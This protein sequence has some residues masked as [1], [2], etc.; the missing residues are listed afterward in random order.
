MPP[1]FIFGSGTSPAPNVS[2]LT[3]LVLGAHMRRHS[4]GIFRMSDS[5]GYHTQEA[6]D[7]PDCIRYYLRLIREDI[8]T[9]QKRSIDEVTYEDVANIVVQLDKETGS[10]RNAAL[11]PYRKHLVKRMVSKFPALD[12]KNGDFESLCWAATEW[13][14]W[15]IY[16]TLRDCKKPP[17]ALQAFIETFLD[18]EL[19]ASIITL[20]H[21]DF[22]EK[23]LGARANLGFRS[24]ES[25]IEFFDA[26][27]LSETSKIRVLKLHGSVDWF[28]HADSCNYRR[29]PIFDSFE[30][31]TAPSLLAGTVSKLESYNF[32]VFPWLWAEFQN[33]LRHTRR[34][35]IS[36]YGFKDIGV[37]VRL[38][39]WLD[40]YPNAQMVI[41]HPKPT[42]L[43]T[44]TK[45]ETL[46]GVVRFFD[47]ATTT[48]SASTDSAAVPNAKIILLPIKFEEASNTIWAPWLKLFLNQVS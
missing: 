12:Q 46:D 34:I 10:R 6:G 32:S 3:E 38:A 40:H 48:I 9:Y 21:D 15:A 35:V 25:G 41:I 14:Q 42:A 27:K 22:L 44:E 20:N 36:G 11:G 39:D 16:H 30:I 24:N 23:I 26:D 18:D 13:I 28:W 45:K 1:S 4:D 2:E 19:P 37:N 8:A 43:I 33:V 17:S 5:G 47:R 7:D 29:L 31:D